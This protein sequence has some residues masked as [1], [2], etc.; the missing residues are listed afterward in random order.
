MVSMYQFWNVR[1]ET[2]DLQRRGDP[3]HL[4]LPVDLVLN[5]HIG[6]DILSNAA[7]AHLFS[8][9]NQR[10]IPEFWL[11]VTSGENPSFP[12]RMVCLR[13]RQIF[14]VNLGLHL[15]K[16]GLSEVEWGIA[17]GASNSRGRSPV[18][19]LAPPFDRLEDC[20]ICCAPLGITDQTGSPVETRCSHAFH[21]QCIRQWL[22]VNPSCPM[23][24]TELPEILPPYDIPG[25]GPLPGW[26]ITLITPDPE[27][28]FVEP[29]VTNQ[30]IALL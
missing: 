12:E 21:E 19:L 3:Q 8:V 11:R 24:R 22:L 13:L 17:M 15:A 16:I 23:C 1:A 4:V 25:D 26:L 7:Q 18:R 5:N 30:D 10:L 14:L 20:A 9:V 27:A 6:L 2:H 28:D 29:L